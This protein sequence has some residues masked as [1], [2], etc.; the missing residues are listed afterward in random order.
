MAF[1]RHSFVARLSTQAIWTLHRW[2]STMVCAQCVLQFDTAVV[3][4]E[5]W[6]CATG[7]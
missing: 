6:L 3:S 1:P 7:S 2:N 5:K 4:Y